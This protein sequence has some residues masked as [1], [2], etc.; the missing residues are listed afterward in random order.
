MIRKLGMLAVAAAFV[1]AGRV[2]AQDST[3]PGFIIA[4]KNGS[5]V[6]GRTLTRDEATGKLRLAMTETAGGEA[7]SYAVIAME[8]ADS[9]R[10]ASTDTDSMRIRLHGGSELRCKE[11]ALNGDVISVKLGSATRVDVRWSEIESISFAP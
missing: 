8:D 5:T 7:R 6:R 3:Q 2:A 1:M 9:I 11:F 10:P 4:L